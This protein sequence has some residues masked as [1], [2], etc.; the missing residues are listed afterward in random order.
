MTNTNTATAALSYANLTIGLSI[1]LFN[2]GVLELAS[3]VHANSG[4]AN[5]IVYLTTPGEFFAIKCGSGSK[6][7]RKLLQAMRASVNAYKGL[8]GDTRARPLVLG[9]KCVNSSVYID[10]TDTAHSGRTL[11]FICINSSQ[12]EMETT[13]LVATPNFAGYEFS[14][15]LFGVKF[16]G[17][18]N[19]AT[20]IHQLATFLSSLA[21]MRWQEGESLKKNQPAQKPSFSLYSL[22]QLVKVFAVNP[23]GQNIVYGMCKALE[24]GRPEII[25]DA[26]AVDI[27]WF[28]NLTNEMTNSH[29]FAHW[30][31][32]IFK[33]LVPKIE[34]THLY[35]SI[36]QSKKSVRTTKI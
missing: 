30:D 31:E 29:R 24:V 5:Q 10:Q 33:W 25:A 34:G 2:N 14:A 3:K 4:N 17:Q 18:A 9:D 21:A 23:V 20:D 36:P 28:I 32:S 11:D 16:S 22:F 7:M 6:H 27:A 35:A 26:S 13:A 15:S 8:T 12:Y 19:S 1:N